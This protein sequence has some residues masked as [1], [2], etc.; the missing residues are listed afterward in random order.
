MNFAY[1]YGGV[2]T[3]ALYI[4]ILCGDTY[5][6]RQTVKRPMILFGRSQVLVTKE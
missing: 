6:P 2:E 3:L 1:T 5:E 4:F